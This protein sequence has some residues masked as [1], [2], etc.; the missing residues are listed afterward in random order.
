MGFPWGFFVLESVPEDLDFA[1]LSGDGGVG[2][3][4]DIGR[5]PVI[6]RSTT[7][8]FLTLGATCLFFELFAGILE[9]LLYFGCNLSPKSSGHSLGLGVCFSFFM[10]VIFC[11]L[12]RFFPS[13]NCLIDSSSASEANFPTSLFICG[14]G[15]NSGVC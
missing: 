5:L 12:F 14:S 3:L 13:S 8:G 11:S 15:S 4:G 10:T 1:T 9:L 6:V 2:G 7:G